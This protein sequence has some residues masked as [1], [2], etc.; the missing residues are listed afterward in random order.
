MQQHHQKWEEEICG[1]TAWRPRTDHVYPEILSSSVFFFF[2]QNRKGQERSRTKQRKT[3]VD[4]KEERHFQD[5]PGNSQVNWLQ[6][7]LLQSDLPFYDL[8]AT[9]VQETSFGL[10]YSPKSHPVSPFLI[11]AGKDT[12]YATGTHKST[13][14]PWSCIKQKQNKNP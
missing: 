2:H 11:K 7:N 3:D 1:D 4:K 12:T 14:D 8:N 9:Q 10:C 13:G 6:L 5:L